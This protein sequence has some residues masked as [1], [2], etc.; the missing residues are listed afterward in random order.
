MA[1][2]RGGNLEYPIANPNMNITIKAD[3][4]VLF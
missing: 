2:R 1:G 4:S 3:D